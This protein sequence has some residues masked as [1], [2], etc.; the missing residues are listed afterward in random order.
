MQRE[1][2]ILV[3]LGRRLKQSGKIQE[4]IAA[5]ERK[6]PWF[7]K[8]FVQNAFDTVCHEMLNEE[9]LQQWRSE[10]NL[11]EVKRTIGLIFA[12]NIPLVGFHDFLCGYVACAKMKIKLSSKDDELFPA[13]LAE[14]FSIDTS[15]KTRIQLV[16]KLE[17][18]NAVI[19]TG[20]NNTNRYFEYYFRDYPKILRHNRNS[21]AV[22]SGSE[23]AEELEKLSDDIFLY[24]G[25][26][27]RNVSKI[28]IPKGY[29]VTSLFPHFEKKYKWLHS[30]SK[31]MNNYDYHR[32]ILL[33]NK[34]P[35]YAN[36]FVMLAENYSIAS[37]I[38]TLHY[39]YWHDMNLL[40][41]SLKSHSSEIQCVVANEELNLPPSIQQV[42]FGQAQRPQ[43]RDYADGMDIIKFLLGL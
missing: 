4:K 3:K 39:E 6:N 10:Y 25:L 30:H 43:L 7:V 17:N 5:A 38:A 29:D 13:V 16:D 20:S 9:K 32:T 21:V 15:A 24:F 22:L 40:T 26:G 19:A 33:L 42:K 1:V 12:G 34:T 18:F 28:F 2:E 36:E 41:T 35:H 23:T 11:K 31:Y 37:S 8:Q 14:L 27:C